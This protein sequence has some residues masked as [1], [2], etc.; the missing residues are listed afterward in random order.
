LCRILVVRCQ[1]LAAVVTFIVWFLDRKV[2][3]PW[4]EQGFPELL[5]GFPYTLKELC[6][7]ELY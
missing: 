3:L 6:H 1:L 2:K 7:L 4:N 5:T